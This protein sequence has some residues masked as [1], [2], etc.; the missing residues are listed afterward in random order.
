MYPASC[1]SVVSDASNAPGPAPL[2]VGLIG[3]GVVGSG[4]CQVLVRN[5]EL[6][7]QRAGRP[8]RLTMAAARNL[9][10]AAQV[11][12]PEVALVSDA[13]SLVRHPDID[14]VVEVMGGVGLA[15][16]LVLEAI[17]QGKHVVTANKAL[18]AE[19]GAEIFAAADAHGVVVAYEAAV[20]VSIPIIKAL[21]EGLAANRIHEVVGIVNGTSNFILSKMD[22]EGLDFAAALRLATAL[23]YA[24]ADPSFDVEGIDAAH[25]T[26]L[27]AAIAFGA[28]VPFAQVHAQGITALD[29]WDMVCARAL[30]YRIKLLGVARQRD[31]AIEVRVH[32]ALVPEKHWLAQVQGSMNGIWVNTDAAGPTFHYGAGA[33][34]QTTASAVVADLIDVARAG[35]A[36]DAQRAALRVPHRAVQPGAIRRWPVLPIRQVVSR[37]YLRFELDESLEHPNDLSDWLQSNG[38]EV[39]Q[40]AHVRHSDGTRRDAL[41][42]LSQSMTGDHLDM[43]LAALAQ[44]PGNPTPAALWRVEDVGCVDGLEP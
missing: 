11:V 40:L 17:V 39:Q 32:P 4:T 23:G 27:L 10:K 37:H 21:R 13:W 9:S 31:D 2:R 26:A 30:G 7:A 15:K 20:A 44:M 6:I 8:I 14:V 28:D 34:S 35:A 19:H 12:G 1:L 5:A 3:T 16:D 25:K 43:A 36:G 29:P 33:G 41:V 42:V 22:D 18:L 38:I 24:E